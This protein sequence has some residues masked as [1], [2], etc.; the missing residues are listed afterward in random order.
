MPLTPTLLKAALLAL[1]GAALVAAAATRPATAPATQPS[2]AHVRELIRQLS[3]DDW[4]AREKAQAAIVDLGTEARPLLERLARDVKEDEARTRLEAALR[5]IEEDDRVSPTLITLR[6]ADASPELVVQ[7]IAR[8]ARVNISAHDV[9][10]LRRARRVTLDVDRQPFWLVM[11]RF[12]EQTGLE[13]QHMGEGRAL[14]LSH[15]R[16]WVRRPYCTHHGFYV[17]AQ[18]VDRAHGL[19]FGEPGKVEHEFNLEFIVYADPRLRII[20]ASHQLALSEVRD[21]NGKS[22][23]PARGLMG[24]LNRIDGEVEDYSGPSYGE[25]WMWN[26][27]AQLHWSPGVGRKIATFRGSA[28]FVIEVKSQRWE[29][30]EPLKLKEPAVR[31]VGNLKYTLRSVKPAGDENMEV[32]VTIESTVGADLGKAPATDPN[33]IQ[34]N[35]RL[36]DEAGRAWEAAGS[37]VSWGGPK[38]DLTFTYWKSPGGWGG[39]GGPPGKPTKLAWHIPTETKEINLPVEFKDLPLP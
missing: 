29:V 18:R 16:E 2:E 38:R 6:H 3:S 39:N 31:E 26:L 24:L 5:Q 4:K 14:M 32:A 25:P 36:L 20:R 30:A 12:C 8:Q 9:D 11:R 17:Q 15:G 37:S 7:D 33:S 27:G 22:L 19:D 1:L 35:I 13:P 10:L 21:E 34:H 28:R 23:L